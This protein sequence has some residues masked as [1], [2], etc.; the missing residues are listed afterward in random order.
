MKFKNHFTYNL[1]KADPLTKAF[2]SRVLPDG[3]INKG[4]CAIGGT[5]LEIENKERSSV[6]T[7]P[8][9]SILL[10]KKE[11]H[12][13]LNIVYGDIS[14]EEVYDYLQNRHVGQ[15]IMSTPEGI[16]KIMWGAEELGI[17]KELYENWFFMLDEAHTFASE[18]YRKDICT[19]FKYFW[20]FKSKC[21]ITATPYFFTHPRMKELDY[22]E[23]VINEKLGKVT[24]VNCVSVVGTLQHILNNINEFPGNV[25]IFYNSVTEIKKA[26]ERAGVEDCNIFCADDRK[27]NNKATLGELVKFYAEQPSETNF[28]KINFYTSRYFEGWDMYDTNATLIAVTDVHKAHTKVGIA[29]KVFQAFGRLRGKKGT[30]EPA[31]PHQLIHITNHLYNNTMKKHADIVTDFTYQAELCINRHNRDIKDSNITKHMLDPRLEKFALLKDKKDVATLEHFKLDQVINTASNAEVYN[32]I[33][34]IKGTWEAKHDVVSQ[35]S[36]ARLQTNTETKRKSASS[37]FKEAYMQLV[38]N[39]DETDGNINFNFG[40]DIKERIKVSDPLAF[41]AYELLDPAQ[42]EAMKFNVKKIEHEVII[43]RNEMAK[44]KL[45][46][47]FDLHFKVGSEYSN[48]TIVN[49]LQAFYDK[50]DIRNKKGSLLIAKPSDL[51]ADGCFEIKQVKVKSSKGTWENGY[52]IIRKQFALAVAA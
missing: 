33:D 42:V 2:P 9:I 16:A 52:R 29:D 10:S 48:K 49:K 6:I 46:K 22:H 23:V 19:P 43:R 20:N 32:H 39:A 45:L 51:G 38:L 12:P 30:I 1:G 44:V 41:E 37:R 13:S 24:L 11:Q 34:L 17:V 7:V 31:Q 21:I 3:F 18:H 5:T 35:S 40:V 36:D 28:K 47:L 26:V 4:R 27:G 50:L 8:N 14:Y 25:H 15:K